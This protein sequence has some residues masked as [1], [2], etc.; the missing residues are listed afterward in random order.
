MRG[1]LEGVSIGVFRFGETTGLLMTSALV[2]PGLDRVVMPRL[3]RRV[4]TTSIR[5]IH[6][7]SAVG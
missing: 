4:L 3:S 1:K 7:A 6:D 5:S 2:E